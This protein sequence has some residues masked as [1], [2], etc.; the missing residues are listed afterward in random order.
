MTELTENN[1]LCRI[2]TFASLMAN[3]V[4][5]VVLKLRAAVAVYLII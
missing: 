1:Y 4:L 3:S 2:I 5:L